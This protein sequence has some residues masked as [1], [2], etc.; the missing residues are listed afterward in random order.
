M[1]HNC[2]ASCHLDVFHALNLGSQGCFQRK[3]Y[4]LACYVVCTRSKGLAAERVS[5]SLGWAGQAH[6]VPL[7]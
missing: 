1:P 2:L 4:D 6:F 5:Q 7:H 3:D